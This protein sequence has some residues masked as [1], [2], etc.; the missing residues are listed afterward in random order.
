MNPPDPLPFTS[1]RPDL[2]ASDARRSFALFVTAPT[3]PP[4]TIPRL[5]P[6]SLALRAPASFVLNPNILT[7][8]PSSLPTVPDVTP[9]ESALTLRDAL[10]EHPMRMLVQSERSEAKGPL[11]T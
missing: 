2:P 4:V 10:S 6:R 3:T 11:T 5:T 8:K 1:G 7:F 9:V